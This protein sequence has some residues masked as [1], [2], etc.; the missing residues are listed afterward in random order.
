VPV[1][2]EG[3][4]VTGVGL[5]TSVSN[6]AINSNGSWIVE[7]DTDNV[8]TDADGVIL[9]NGALLFREGQ[10]LSLPVGALLDSFD[11]I[12][13]NAGEN[14]SYNFFLDGTTGTSDDSGVYFN[15]NLLIQESNISTATAFTPGTPYIGFFETKINAS[16][17]IL[18][19]ASIDDPNI[20]STVDRAL[21]VLTVDGSG[22]L[23]SETVFIKEEDIP[24]G[25]TEFLADVETNP[26]QFA[27]NDN[28]DIMY[29]A[30]LNGDTAVDGVVYVN[31]TIVGQEGSASPVIGRNWS[32]LGSGEVDLNNSGEYVIS[33]SLDG[34]AASTLLI[35][36]SGAKFMQEGDSPA[37]I[38]PFLLTPFGSGPVLISDSGDVVWFGDW[39]DP[40]TD[41][42]TGLFL[43]D[44]LLIQEGVTEI[45]GVVV[46]DLRGIQD[47]Y[48]LSR[49]GRWLLFEA[50]LLDG[51]EGAYLMALCD[52]ASIVSDNPGGTNPTSYTALARDEN[53]VPNGG[54]P[55]L[56][57]TITWS[58]NASGTTG[59]TRSTVLGYLAGT[60]TTLGGGQVLL[61]DVGDPNGEVFG[62][63]L[64]A[65]DF[66]AQGPIP[67][68]PAL[69]GIPVFAQGLHV[70]GVRPFALSNRHVFTV[71]N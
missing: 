66:L 64:P 45:G 60:T 27:F 42:D 5:I 25:Q 1:V 69:C 35:E 46:G 55:V 2:Q 40:D 52:E 53:G 23:A 63:G 61:V 18:V 47:G 6:L 4:T 24:P 10:A 26:H 33:G 70:G 41:V 15:A 13:L 39:D 31:S 21:V 14:A 50:L 56:G 38:A 37:P 30:D 58:V 57:G 34:D 22:N 29:I 48:A 12:S 17:D 9:E 44:R 20:T 28:G 19:V 16:N 68:N 7:A 59:H 65:G 62:F 71:G 11:S 3:D 51:T 43:N 36:K 54:E 67:L 32:I 8:D 49:D